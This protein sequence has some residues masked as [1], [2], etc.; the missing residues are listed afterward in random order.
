[1]INA[2]LLLRAISTA[3]LA[4]FVAVGAAD[5]QTTAVGPAP[6]H[7][8]ATS[9]HSLTATDLN[10]FLDGFVPFAIERGDVAGA[11]VS[12]VKDGQILVNRGYGYAD[13][14]TRRPVSPDE[15]LFRPGSIGKLFTWTAVMQQVE[16]GKLNLDRDVNDY[17][18]FKIPP[19][20]GKPITLRNL[21]TH[22]PGFEDTFKDSF[23][24][25]PS[26][27]VP[28]GDYLKSHIPRRIFP[29]GEIVAYSNYG[30]SL[31]GYIVQRVSGQKYADYIA[32]NIFQPLGMSHS[33][34][35]QPLPARLAPL[36]SAGYKAASGPP[37][38]FEFIEVA[39][40]G[41]LSST[42]ADMAKFMIAQ[43]QNGR[44]GARQI[45]KPAT[46]RLMHTPQH[47]EAP[48]LN[49]FDLGFYDENR[50]GRRIIGHAGDTEVFHSDL[51]LILD[52]NVGLFMSFNSTGANGAVVRIRT[53]LFAAFLDR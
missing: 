42:S 18:D 21:L 31:A 44:L 8:K 22:T 41:A 37:V 9:Q 45:L 28:L 25:D 6:P 14:K 5:A 10:A 40:A 17:L 3:T 30:A 52:A 38:P 36:M 49:G 35:L 19:A 15:T 47:T 48:G 43:L 51:H 27:L 11:V 46:A 12:V 53:A 24:K 16:R 7:L 20:F 2:S 26:R 4:I 29:P 50:N 34:M 13:L 32:E 33:T 39:P 23:V 1:M